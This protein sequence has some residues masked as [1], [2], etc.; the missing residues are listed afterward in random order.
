MSLAMIGFFFGYVVGG[1]TGIALTAVGV[2]DFKKG[3]GDSARR[4]P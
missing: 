1:L 2:F 4:I 3:R